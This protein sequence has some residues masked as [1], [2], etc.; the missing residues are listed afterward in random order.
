MTTPNLKRYVSRHFDHPTII[1][2]DG[3]EGGGGYINEID[4]DE[5]FDRHLRRQ[6]GRFEVNSPPPRQNNRRHDRGDRG[7]GGGDGMKRGVDNDGFVIVNLDRDD[8]GCDTAERN[9]IMNVAYPVL[10]TPPSKSLPP[11]INGTAALSSQGDDELSLEFDEETSAGNQRQKNIIFATSIKQEKLN[12]FQGVSFEQTNEDD[13]SYDE[14][15][16]KPL[17]GQSDKSD[18]KQE[19]EEVEDPWHDCLVWTLIGLTCLLVLAA[20]YMAIYLYWLWPSLSD[21]LTLYAVQKTIVEFVVF[22]LA[23]LFVNSLIILR[24][25]P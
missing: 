7:G 8:G 24:I 4:V 21:P 20:C 18:G 1:G 23:V 10:S 22:V 3:S 5:S 25:F 13:P 9:N 12:K 15:K 6:V 14:T 11:T 19:D 17:S 16:Q 2:D